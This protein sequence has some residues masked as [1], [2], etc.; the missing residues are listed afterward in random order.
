ME[1]PSRLTEFALNSSQQAPFTNSVTSEGGNMIHLYGL[2]ASTK[3]GDP[4]GSKDLAHR[5]PIS[6][7]PSVNRSL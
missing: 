5:W 4:M 7:R 6:M 3:D 1:T 2:V